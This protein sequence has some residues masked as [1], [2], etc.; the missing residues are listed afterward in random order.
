[1]G[2]ASGV[3]VL[4]E[5]HEA[6]KKER[7]PSREVISGKGAIAGTWHKWRFAEHLRQLGDI[8]DEFIH[9]PFL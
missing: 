6:V 4:H 3:E 8:L 5:R 9:Q 2:E 1:M 7:F